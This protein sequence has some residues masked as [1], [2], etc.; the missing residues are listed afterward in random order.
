MQIFVPEDYR[1]VF[2]RSVRIAL[3]CE[4]G[5][6]L[7]A[8]NQI[9]RTDTALASAA[10]WAFTLDDRMALLKDAEAATGTANAAPRKRASTGGKPAR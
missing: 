1:A 2:E 3:L 6:P 8:F 9:E 10:A 4:A 5:Q 7:Q